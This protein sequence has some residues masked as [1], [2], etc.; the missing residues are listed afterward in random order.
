MLYLGI[1]RNIVMLS[2]CSQ[3]DPWPLLHQ[4][5]GLTQAGATLGVNKVLNIL[6]LVLQIM[7]LLTKYSWPGKDD[8]L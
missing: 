8:D 3:L 1:V 7:L 4:G 2:H 5:A 6:I